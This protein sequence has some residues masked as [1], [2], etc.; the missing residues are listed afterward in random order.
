MTNKYRRIN[1]Y[2]YMYTYI[3]MYVCLLSNFIVVMELVT[4]K[5]ARLSLELLMM[6]TGVCIHFWK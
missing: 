3:H 6:P 2:V 5:L 1:E 4:E